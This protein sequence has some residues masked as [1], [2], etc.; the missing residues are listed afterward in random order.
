MFS[1]RSMVLANGAI[2]EAGD[3]KLDTA[4]RRASQ[5]PIIS[6]GGNDARSI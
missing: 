6:A 3:V 2:L 1:E 4:Q 5:W